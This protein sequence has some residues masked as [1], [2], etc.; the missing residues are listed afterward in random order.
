MFF[1]FF[2]YA[3]Q[4]IKPSRIITLPMSWKY[5][6]RKHQTE[7]KCRVD[8]SSKPVPCNIPKSKVTGTDMGPTWWAHELCYL[9]YFPSLYCILVFTGLKGE[10]KHIPWILKF[11]SIGTKPNDLKKIARQGLVVSN[12]RSIQCQKMVN[13]EIVS[14]VA[15]HLH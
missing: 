2:F 9:G 10:P 15:S 14:F 7:A 3:G 12:V 11:K 6:L 8:L 13:S 5:S 1:L 4:V